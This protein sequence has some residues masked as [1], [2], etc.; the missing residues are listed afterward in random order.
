M[1]TSPMKFW[2]AIA[3]LE[4]DQALDVARTADRA[5]YHGIT[6]SDHIAYPK[7][8]SSPY[9]YS[10]D[11][12]PIWA[13]ETPWPDPWCLISAMAGVT[14]ELRFT[15]NIYVAP[16]RDLFTVA[17]AVSTASVISGGRVALGLAAGWCR[18]EFELTGQD[19]ARRGDRLDEMM[20]VLPQLWS[21]EWVEHHGEFYDFQ[22]LQMAPVPERKIPLY[23]GGISDAAMRRAARLGDGWIGNAY[24]EEEAEVELERLRAHLDA[25]GRS[26]DDSFEVIIA[27]LAPPKPDI[28]KRFE[29]HGVTGI[30]CAPWMMA[31]VNDE[32]YGSPLDARIA[33][34]ERFAERVITRMS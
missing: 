31:D 19:F 16:A 3:F 2:Q 1:S 33:A 7:E 23:V 28:Y 8:L 15:T 4:T 17:K 11:G 30:V 10:K 12:R 5:G 24:T 14:S 22:A 18:E 13:P 29:E 9:P 25:A 32:R 21:G 26:D 20:N 6:V 34:I 27:L